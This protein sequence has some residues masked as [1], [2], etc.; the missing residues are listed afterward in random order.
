MK[1]NLLVKEQFNKQADNFNEWSITRDEKILQSLYDFWDIQKN[2]RLL[3]VACGTGAFAVYAGQRTRAVQGVDISENM[4]NIAIHNAKRQQLKNVSFLCSDV[5][6]LPF[7]SKSFES[8]ISKAAFHHMK[9]YRRVFREM[10]RCCKQQGRICLH[11]VVKYGEKTPDDFFEELERQIDISHQ[12]SLSKQQII[13]LYHENNIKV[14][15]LFE[16]TPELDFTDYLHHA[17]QTANA[18]EKIGQLVKTGSQNREIAAWLATRNN[19]LFWK[20]KILTI[21]GQK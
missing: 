21:V 11:D 2:D 20:R 8:V 13:D 10:V 19:T 3:D 16:S 7:E 4:I 6:K 17:V 1:E 9:N 15:R 14:L 12:V 18:A 5:E